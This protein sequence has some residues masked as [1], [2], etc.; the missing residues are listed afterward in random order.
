MCK[1]DLVNLPECKGMQDLTGV[2]VGQEYLT[3]AYLWTRASR[4]PCS[5]HSHH[6]VHSQTKGVNTCPD[7]CIKRLLAVIALLTDPTTPELT[8]YDVPRESY[9]RT[10]LHHVGVPLC[11]QQ[12]TLVSNDYNRLSVVPFFLVIILTFFLKEVAGYKAVVLSQPNLV[13]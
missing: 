8:G 13:I 11:L 5:V 2:T 1:G 4:K 7:L 9:D 10:V 6:W 3:G 12:D